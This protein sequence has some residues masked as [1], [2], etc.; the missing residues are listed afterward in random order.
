MPGSATRQVGCS[1]Y[2]LTAFW[3]ITV[4][5]AEVP[6]GRLL[7]VCILGLARQP[8]LGVQGGSLSPPGPFLEP[9]FPQ[10][11]PCPA[12]SPSLAAW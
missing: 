11:I 9:V 4:F 5:G 8:S 1:W 2:L 12:G 6:L 10:I 3:V 7:T